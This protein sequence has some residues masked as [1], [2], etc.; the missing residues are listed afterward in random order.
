VVSADGVIHEFP[1]GTELAAIDRVVKEYTLRQGMQFAAEAAI[2][3][4]V[5]VLM[6]GWA[7]VWACRGF[8]VRE[9]R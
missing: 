7:L 6:V 2:V 1:A 8:L 3:P 4:P 5:F 9:R